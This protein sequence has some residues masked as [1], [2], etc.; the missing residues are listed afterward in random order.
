MFGMVAATGVR[1]L[2]GVDFHA[3]PNYLVIVASSLGLGMIP[4]LVSA[5]I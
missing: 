3:N 5:P 2:S 4:T 1:I